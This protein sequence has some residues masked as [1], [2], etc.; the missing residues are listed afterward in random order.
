MTFPHLSVSMLDTK[1]CPAY[2]VFTRVFFLQYNISYDPNSPLLPALTHA[3]RVGHHT[4]RVATRVR[5]QTARRRTESPGAG[6]VAH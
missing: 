2:V 3:G 6:R 1:K 5:R 4:A